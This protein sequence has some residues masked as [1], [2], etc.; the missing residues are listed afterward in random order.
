MEPQALHFGHDND[1]RKGPTSEYVL[2]M[3]DL[4]S[5]QQQRE[6]SPLTQP[7]NAARLLERIEVETVYS[8]TDSQQPS[9]K[10][11]SPKH[12]SSTDMLA[13]LP[14]DMARAVKFAMTF[15]AT[16]LLV[17]AV[18]TTANAAQH[19]TPLVPLLICWVVLASFGL[20]LWC[21]LRVV[22]QEC[23]QDVLLHPL[24]Q[25][26]TR[27]FRNEYIAFTEDFQYEYNRLLLTD[28]D[29]SSS[30]AVTP[31]QETDES[32]YHAMASD[33]TASATATR[34]QKDEEQNKT[35]SRRPKSAVF[36]TLVLPVMPLF[37]RRRKRREKQQNQQSADMKNQYVPPIV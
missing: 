20:V 1:T 4:R 15:M 5:W 9:D 32:L 19:H 27:H 16:L 30:S 37:A 13:K 14:A 28:G 31:H 21:L 12:D 23:H 3:S 34:N 2:E 22:L 6:A 36:R 18:L 26:V 25:A 29:P 35:S 17:A 24:V 33:C 8:E 10:T 7:A 11:Y